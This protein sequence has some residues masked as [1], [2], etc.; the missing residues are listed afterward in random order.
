MSDPTEPMRR[1]R[2][3]EI[4]AE[5]GSQEALQAVHGQVWDKQQLT[6]DF[7]VIGFMAPLVVV[8]RKSD[9]V[10]GSF[11]FQHTPRLYFNWR[12]HETTP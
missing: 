4:N 10:K 3:V 1:R 5:P 6:E 12:P 11:E 9:G 8:R 7:E 2:L